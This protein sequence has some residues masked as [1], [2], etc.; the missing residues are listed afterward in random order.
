MLAGPSSRALST[1]M[2][3]VYSPEDIAEAKALL[4]S[5]VEAYVGWLHK[6]DPAGGRWKRRYFVLRGS[7]LSYY[8]DDT[9]STLKGT[10]QL[11]AHHLAEAGIGPAAIV[12]IARRP[13]VTFPTPH[14]L[15]LGPPQVGDAHGGAVAEAFAHAAAASGGASGGPRAFF[16]AAETAGVATAW[17]A[18]L[19]HSINALRTL[20]G[21][22]LRGGPAPAP[23]P[24]PA[25][26]A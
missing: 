12:G 9:R 2:G 11:T 24:A 13:V 23:A 1:A 15:Y 16:T 19:T 20:E 26:R 6:S 8:T 14:P 25:R 7:A 5:R 17:A 21:L 18:A 3:G 22:P 10:V 4:M